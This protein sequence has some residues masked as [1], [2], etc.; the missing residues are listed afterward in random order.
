MMININNWDKLQDK[1]KEYWSLE[2]HDRPLYSIK[3]PKEGY[4]SA[5]VIPP[6]L[7]KDRWMDTEYI[8][9]NSR[10]SFNATYFGGEAFP[11][12]WPNLGPDILG[13]TI[14]CDITFGEYTSW[15]EHFVEDWAELKELKFD[16]NNPW[17]VKIRT[18]TEA[19]VEDA[20]HGDYLVGITDLHPGMDG[21]VSLRGPE[22]LCYDVV[23]CPEEVKKF[24]SQV[25]EVYKKEL[26]ELYA[27]TTRYQKGS[28]HWMNLWH[29]GK[30]YNTSCDFACMVSGDMFDEFILPEILEEL[31]LVDASIF[32]LDGPGA[33]KH[34]DKLLQIPNLNGIQWVYGAGQ[35][36]ARHWI[37]VLK[38]IQAAGKCIHID[39]THED[40][41]TLLSELKPEGLYMNIQSCATEQDAVD[42][43]K[44]IQNSYKKTLY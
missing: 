44:K 21:L 42:I 32:H 18:M 8:I 34:L 10:E 24:N 15:A 2:N 17:W 28:S 4:N 38:K 35:P 9:K 30:W 40:L 3:A 22:N 29:P 27:L 11:Q 13:A 14:G 31:K 36:T 33:L 6:P 23:D 37:P 39:V 26:Q 20:K 19:I 25:F 16:E 1:F 43:T 12:L 7:L 41:D 5:V